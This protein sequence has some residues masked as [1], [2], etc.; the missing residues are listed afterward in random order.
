MA[1][2]RCH[3]KKIKCSGGDPV[4]N[5]ACRH[6]LSAHTA[7]V[8]PTRHRNVTVAESYL[9]ALE[10]AVTQLT[11]P[12]TLPLPTTN[13]RWVAPTLSHAGPHSSK[14]RFIEDTTGDA[15][16]IRLKSLTQQT[17]FGTWTEGGNE[18]QSN[19][20]SREQA[21]VPSYEYFSLPSDQPSMQ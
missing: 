16:T 14:R 21:G 19:S 17:S 8:Y 7:C 13:P 12:E 6:C 18:S 10:S 9:K 1:C 5:L 20:V 11:T 15:F 4:R 3:Q 2:Q